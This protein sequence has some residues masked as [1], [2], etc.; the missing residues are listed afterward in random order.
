MPAVTLGP[1][2]LHA[3]KYFNRKVLQLCKACICK[4]QSISTEIVG[5]RLVTCMPKLLKLLLEASA[6][7]SSMLAA[8]WA[9]PQ[10]RAEV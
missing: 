9:A 2:S 10:Q 4:F 1:S 3:A 5:N 6:A 8:A 7:T